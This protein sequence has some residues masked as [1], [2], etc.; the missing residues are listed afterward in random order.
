M[1]SEINGILNKIHKFCTFGSVLGLSR[2]EELCEKL[3]HP[4]ENLNVIHVAG[5]NGKGSVCRYIYEVLRT[6]GYLVG[7]YTSPFITVFNERIEIN[8]SYI[9]DED[10]IY[11]SELVLNIAKEMKEPPTEFELI[12]AI[13]LK[14]F[15]DKKL[16]Y[17]ILE[18][19]LG[20]RGDSTNIV[21]TPLISVISSIGLDHTDRLGNSL[22]EIAWEKAGIIKN[23]VPVIS[24]VIP[25]K[26]KEVISRT[27]MMK[28]AEFIDTSELEYEILNEDIYR[29]EYKADG[30][31]LTITMGGKHQITNSLT[32]YETLK[33]LRNMGKLSVTDD[34]IIKG[35]K[36]ARQ[37]GRF[38]V[39]NKD[40]YVIIDGAH[41]IDGVVA[42]SSTLRTNFKDSK[43]LL[44][45][46]ILKDKAYNNMA[47][48]LVKITD[49]FIVTEPDNL[50]KLSAIRL[51]EALESNGAKCLI[52]PI[53][54]EAYDRAMEIKNDYDVIV[55]AGSLYLVS[56][57]RSYLVD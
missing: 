55:F 40:P 52:E 6:S 46:G 36:K 25:E 28:S 49:E 54:K 34:D 8:G 15:S 7:L 44:V 29:S 4:E 16:D 11:Y 45:V 22:A 9:D 1:E 12:T 31:N 33:K 43:I 21:K 50:R 20:G 51:S 3:S 57:V 47:K 32:A 26:A 30:L 2:M 41:N 23:N 37:P 18:V 10:L 38:E 24:A 39:F 35:F 19:G 48:E 17:V 56:E 42:L 5:T 14:Y 27:A 13:G 53:L